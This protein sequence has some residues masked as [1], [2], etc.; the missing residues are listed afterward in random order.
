[1]AESDPSILKKTIV[2]AKQ[3]REEQNIVPQQTIVYNQTYTIEDLI[4][5]MI[6]YSDNTAYEIL[7]ESIDYK[8]FMDLFDY[9]G[10]DFSKALTDPLGNIISVKDYAAFYR[11]LF[12]A[13]YLNKE[14]SEKALKLLS[15]TTYKN[16]L[17]ARLPSNL[18]VA[19]KFGER[20]Y[21]VTAEVQLHDCGIVYLPNHPYLI[22]VMTRGKDFASLE[23]VIQDISFVAYQN[24]FGNSNWKFLCHLENLSLTSDQR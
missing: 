21:L 3:T 9:L 1:M 8:K 4:N 24:S 20:K 10:V 5:R 19:H 11:I 6:I 7:S 16:G 12:N 17:V 23:S 18:I 2:N 22:C 13:S 15:Q 14:M